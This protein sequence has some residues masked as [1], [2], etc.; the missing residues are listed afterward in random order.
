MF[1][2]VFIYV[3]MFIY[4]KG[5]SRGKDQSSTLYF[6]A[7][8]LNVLKIIVYFVGSKIFMTT[9]YHGECP[10]TLVGRVNN[11]CVLLY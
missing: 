9:S 1:T 7:Y 11:P 6:N 2:K 4:Q 10:F 5:S 3:Y 8:F